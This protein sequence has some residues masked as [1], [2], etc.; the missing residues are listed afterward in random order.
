MEARKVH[1]MQAVC[2]NRYT[3]P[4]VVVPHAYD[5]VGNALRS[6]YA[7]ATVDLPAEFA[8][9]LDKLR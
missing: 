4:D 9:L 5:G 2:Q 1:T 6:S 3:T 7:S 8:E